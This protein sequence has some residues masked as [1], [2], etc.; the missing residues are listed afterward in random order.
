MKR[1][2]A[3]LS[4]LAIL[5]AL[6]LL[7][8]AVYLQDNPPAEAESHPEG[9]I[10]TVEQG[11]TLWDLAAKYLGSPW[12]WQDLWERNR[13]LTNPHYIYPGIKIVIF[14]P[15][16]KEYALTTGE[17]A[18]AGP[19][20]PAAPAPAEDVANKTE[21]APPVAAPPQ[22]PPR[23]P[24]LD[25]S[26]SEFVQAGEFLRQA[27]RGI[28]AI[29]GGE[30]SKVAFSDGD[31]VFLK[32]SKE[33]PAGQ[34]LGVYRVRG[35]ITAPGGRPISGYVTHLVGVVQAGGKENGNIAGVVRNSF[36]DLGRKDLISE[37]IPA[38]SPVTLS[39]GAP[40]LEATVIAGQGQKEDLSAGDIIFLDRGAGAGV[41]VGNVFRL[42]DLRGGPSGWRSQ[43]EG[44]VRVEVGRAVVVRVS[45]EFSTAYVVK[46]TQ[47][48]PAGVRA[49]GAPE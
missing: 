27:P 12:R 40:G 26:P 15:P 42:F 20:G 4:F 14:P 46:S 3:V 16:P 17:A 41:A 23:K 2:A 28:G 39:P 34:L 11:E 13:F 38:Y 8:A 35:P 5:G 31:K 47:S 22:A 45:P 36:E 25:I 24:T 49:V 7:P 21:A 37:T 33:I 43:R 29:R 19:A 10:H 32:L 6:F 44:R 1:R 48:F 30:E 18:P 9:L